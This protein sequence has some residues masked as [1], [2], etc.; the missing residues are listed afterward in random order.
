MKHGLGQAP[1]FT[2]VIPTYQRRERLRK[3]LE[4]IGRQVYPRD[5]LEVVVVCDGC[6]DGSAEMARS[7]RLPVR[8]TVIEQVNQG[9]AVARNTGLARA[10][11]PYVLF[12]DDDVIPAPYLVAEH[13]RAHD[14]TEDRVVI[15]PLLSSTE[16]ARSWV[17]WESAKLAEQYEL[18]IAGIFKPTPY[19]FYT[20]NAS[21]LLCRLLEV[22]GFDAQFTRGEDVEL[23]L[24]LENAGS[25]FH[26]E[27]RA[28]SVHMADRPYASWRRAAYQYG[29]ND[30]V[31]T[32]RDNAHSFQRMSDLFFL[33]HPVLRS[34]VRWTLAYRAMRSAVSSGAGLLARAAP[35][36]GANTIA[37]LACSVAFN[38]EYWDGVSHEIG[39]RSVA[40]ALTKRKAFDFPAIDPARAVPKL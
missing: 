25:S 9:P 8:L 31:F 4:A 33:R 13:A 27:P 24:R 2:V 10:R 15:G 29:R 1:G 38:V 34:A 39:G 18:M 14:H 32:R 17:E 3:V 21:V 40:L 26:F 36:V 7:L 23:A 6:T 28:G 5:R 35:A 30:V 12:I 22:G 16:R 11:G 37:Q 19:Q 20:G